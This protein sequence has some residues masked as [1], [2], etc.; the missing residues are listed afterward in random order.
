MELDAPQ[1]LPSQGLLRISSPNGCARVI[2]LGA[3]VH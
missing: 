1:H 2:T 3:A